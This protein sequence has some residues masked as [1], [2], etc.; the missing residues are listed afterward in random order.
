MLAMAGSA[1]SPLAS[2]LRPL[3]S[4]S[5]AAKGLSWPASSACWRCASPALISAGYAGFSA[6]SCTRPSFMP[7]HTGCAFQLPAITALATCV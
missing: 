2:R 6:D 7:P 5:G 1:S 4:T 3:L